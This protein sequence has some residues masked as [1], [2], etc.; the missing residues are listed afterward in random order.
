MELS[1]NIR[2]LRKNKECKV[3]LPISL[4]Q[5]KSKLG[6]SETED[7]EYII[8]DSSCGFVK[9]YDSL[10]TLNEFYDLVSEVDADIVK[11]VRDVTGYDVKDFVNYDFNFED[12]YI[13]PDVTTRKELGQYWFNE[14]G[15]EGVG[16]ENMERYFD[17]EAYGR[18]IDLES[19][20]GFTDYGYVEIRG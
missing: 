17:C 5:L 3:D 4:E 10:E 12:C 14:L 15:A 19:G 18:D 8:V 16:K 11:A 20:G 2:A 13:L 9:E 6:F 7:F 1:V